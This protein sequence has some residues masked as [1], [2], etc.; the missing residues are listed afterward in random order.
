MSEKTGCSPPGG[1]GGTRKTWTSNES[2]SLSNNAAPRG[3]CAAVGKGW[4]VGSVGSS[5]KTRRAGS[6]RS[7]GLLKYNPS[8]NAVGWSGLAFLQLTSR[9]TPSASGYAAGLPT[10]TF[11]FGQFSSLLSGTTT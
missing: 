8:G 2:T 9:Y 1:I 11:A 10:V 5:W 6:T 3:G 7:D 4:R